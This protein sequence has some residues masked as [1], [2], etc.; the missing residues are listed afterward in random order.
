MRDK[1]SA[2]KE[3]REIPGVGKQVALDLWGLGVRAIPDLKK[4]DPEN[5]YKQLC[6]LQGQHI[7]R[8]ML[9]TF[10]CAVY[11]AKTKKPNPELLKWW[12]WKD[13]S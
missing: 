12:A 1:Y 6:R 10:R 9:Y 3:L 7:D 8:C 4:K 13:K 11:Y 5:L 2:L